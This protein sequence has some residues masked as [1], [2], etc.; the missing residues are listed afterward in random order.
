MSISDGGKNGKGRYDEDDIEEKTNKR[1]NDKDEEMA[2]FAA[3]PAGGVG[4]VS[5]AALNQQ[6]VKKDANGRH[7][8]RH[9]PADDN[10]A[11]GQPLDSPLQRYGRRQIPHQTVE[12]PKHANR[13]PQGAEEGAQQEEVQDHG[14][15]LAVQRSKML[16]YG[17]NKIVA[18]QGEDQMLL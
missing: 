6:S 17:E 8:Q 7:Q 14:E 15:Y 4:A 1:G 9:A 3:N 18:K 11:F 12:P 13:D 2:E 5:D 16:P 10:E